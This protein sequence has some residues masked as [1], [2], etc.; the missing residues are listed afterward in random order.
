MPAL[1]RGNRDL[2]KAMNRN[3]L[4]NILRREGA[5]SRTQ[6]TE[7]SGLSVGAVSQITTELILDRWIL[8]MGEGDYTGGR[9][10]VLLKLNPTMGYALGLKLMEDRAVC[11]V[12]NF[13]ARVLHYRE[14]PLNAG[15][16]PEAISDALA[17]IINDVI[18]SSG[19]QHDQFFGIGVGLAGVIYGQRGIV[20]YSPFFG[21]RD[22]PLAH[23]LQ[24]RLGLPVT[25]ENDVNTLTL[26]EHLFGAGRQCSNLVVVTI[27][28]GIG[29]GMIVNG[30]LYH[31]AQGGAGELGHTII[32][33][34]RRPAG[35]LEQLASDPAVLDAFSAAGQAIDLKAVSAMA[36][37]GD[38]RSRALLAASG[39]YLGIALANVVNILSPEMLIVS[40][41]GVLAGSH[42]LDPMLDALKRHA[43]NGLLDDVQVVI[44]PT[45]DQAWARGAASL[46]LSK[47]FESPL[48]EI[49]AAD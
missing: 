15:P 38:D 1:K 5:L 24:A 30:Q 23:M 3:L 34:S 6:L 32:D 11:A 47:V 17:Q 2:I 14:Q 44:E 46:V 4:V 33:A 27:G 49:D 21:W 8:E 25:I 18:A 7:I 40:G 43:F 28:R 9:R 39:D 45:D 10:Q 48:V 19:L 13:D 41:E 16:Q 35:S 31:G 20:H 12:T 37:A 36:Q 22:V 29:M 26:T 42:R